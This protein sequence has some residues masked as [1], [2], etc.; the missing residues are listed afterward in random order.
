[1]VVAGGGEKRG[2][3]GE[4]PPVVWE[5]ERIGVTSLNEGAAVFGVGG[6]ERVDMMGVGEGKGDT[7]VGSLEKD[8][9]WVIP[10]VGGRGVG[11]L[12]LGAATFA[13]EAV[14]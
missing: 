5:R 2:G 12:T 9:E 4:V 11:M 7:G 8:P 6:K 3:N 13:A 10:G 1:V 14:L